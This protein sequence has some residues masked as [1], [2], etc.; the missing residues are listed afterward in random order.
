[1]PVADEASVVL[2]LL[3]AG[4]GRRVGGPTPKAFRTV[5]DRAMLAV[6]AE[7]VGRA[8]EVDAMVVAVPPGWEDRARRALDE[9]AVAI[10]AVVLAGGASRHESV[11]LALDR[12]PAGCDIV[13]CHDAARPFATPE[14]CGRVVRELRARG[15]DV[16]G[17]VPVVEV[18]DTLKRVRGGEV[19]STESRDALRAAQ[20]PQALRASALRLAHARARREGV[21]FSDDAGVVEWNGERVVAIAGEAANLK[22]TT[23]DDLAL[24]SAMAA[25]V[26]AP[27][28]HGGEPRD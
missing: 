26:E 11:G 22:I 3:A 12:V 10:P 17:C 4:S 5:G 6:A 25:R 27:A 2:V 9:A 13:V 23:D 19:I 16:A 15:P 7:R 1:M 8:P 14:L 20:T 28:G 24:A 21:E 18:A